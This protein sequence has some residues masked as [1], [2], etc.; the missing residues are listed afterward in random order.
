MSIRTFKQRLIL[1]KGGMKQ[2][3]GIKVDPEIKKTL[4]KLADKES[5]NL[6]NFCYHAIK[7]YV[8]EH[9]KVNIEK[10]TKK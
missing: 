1:L 8:K 7:I 5:R 2:M 9:F 4:Q 10:E 3:I 6:S